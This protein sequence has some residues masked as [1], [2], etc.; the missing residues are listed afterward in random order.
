MHF[1][2]FLQCKARNHQI[3]NL[4][5]A[6]KRQIFLTF[7]IISMLRDV[8]TIPNALAFARNYQIPNTKLSPPLTVPY[9]ANVTS[10][11]E[12]PFSLIFAPETDFIFRFTSKITLVVVYISPGLQRFAQTRESSLLLDRVGAKWSLSSS[13][14]ENKTSSTKKIKILTKSI[15]RELMSTRFAKIA[16]IIQQK[17]KLQAFIHV[18]YIRRRLRAGGYLGKIYRC[19]F[20]NIA[21]RSWV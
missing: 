18:I 13:R 17:M 10:Y 4:R 1:L 19:V 2:Q 9:Y 7:L 11:T 8:M 12:K 16:I 14:V 20:L 21:D 6:L 15:S 5:Y 3:Q